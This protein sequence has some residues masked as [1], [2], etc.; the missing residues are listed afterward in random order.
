MG[1]PPRSHW[2]VNFTPLGFQDPVFAVNVLLTFAAP[3]MVG[4]FGLPAIGWVFDDVVGF[5]AVNAF[6][7]VTVTVILAPMSL[8]TSLY[9]DEVAPL[10]FLPSRFH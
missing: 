7:V 4:F 10:I 1:L 3:G 8:A 2:Y 9:A 5:A 6:D